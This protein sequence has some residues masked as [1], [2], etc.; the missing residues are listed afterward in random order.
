MV[1]HVVRHRD[2]DER[3]EDGAMHWDAILP[4][5]RKKFQSQ[6]EKESKNRSW[7]ECLY[8]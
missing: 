5:L 1:T 6:L 3:E 4:I 2:R 7:V 8:R